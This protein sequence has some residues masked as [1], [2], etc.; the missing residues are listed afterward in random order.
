MEFFKIVDIS[1][2]ETEIHEKIRN[3]QISEINPEII[4]FITNN[5]LA[6]IGCLWGEFTLR[7]DVIKGGIRFGM[8]ECPNALVWTITTGYPPARDK[9]V[10]HLTI[11]RTQKKPEFVEEINEFIDSW[12]QGLK[13][14][15]R[16]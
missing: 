3:E 8:L 9:L 14:F 10:I 6:Q 11:N 4:L 5:D 1:I 2:S 15:F 12:A 16:E 7:R 13:T